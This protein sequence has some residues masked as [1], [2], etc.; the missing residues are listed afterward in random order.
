MVQGLQTTSCERGEACL[1][2]L[3][4]SS[5]IALRAPEVNQTS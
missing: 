3:F 5:D 2:K 4:L 1:L